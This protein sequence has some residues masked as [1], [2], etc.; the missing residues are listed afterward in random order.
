MGLNGK[1]SASAPGP[2]LKNAAAAPVVYFDNVPVFGTFGGNIEI[3]LAARLLMPKADGSVVADMTCTAHLRAS[4]AA[5]A[6]LMDACEKALS[7]HARQQA[8]QQPQPEERSTLL[9]S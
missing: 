6:M 2:L 4:P 5:V 9:N 8:E 3:E 1:S 7:M